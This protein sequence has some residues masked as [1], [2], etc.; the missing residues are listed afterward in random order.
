MNRKEIADIITLSGIGGLEKEIKNKEFTLGNS[1]VFN[2]KRAYQK[3][4]KFI[5]VLICSIA[6]R[7]SSE[8]SATIKYKD[9]YILN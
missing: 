2:L 9:F 1:N 6:S 4:K 8:S 5:E 7:A 3:L